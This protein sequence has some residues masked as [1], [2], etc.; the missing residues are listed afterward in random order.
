MRSPNRPT[1]RISLRERRSCAN[2]D[3]C[4]GA[5]QNHTSISRTPRLRKPSHNRSWNVPHRGRWPP[6][7]QLRLQAAG[8]STETPRLLRAV[9]KFVI[10]Q[11]TDSFPLKLRSSQAVAQLPLIRALGGECHSSVGSHSSVGTNRHYRCSCQAHVPPKLTTPADSGEETREIIMLN[12][13]ALFFVIARSPRSSAL[14]ESQ[15]ARCRLQ[16][17]FSL[18]SFCCSSS[19]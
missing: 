13:A 12:Y 7:S 6:H 17:S 16:R 14:A 3:A 10:K 8:M 1:V 18:S 2:C 11:D 19:H 5:F 4:P 9:R 15:P